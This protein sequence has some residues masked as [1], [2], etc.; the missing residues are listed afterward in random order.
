MAYPDGL[1]HVRLEQFPGQHDVYELLRQ[2][3]VIR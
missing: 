1:N 3:D 2:H